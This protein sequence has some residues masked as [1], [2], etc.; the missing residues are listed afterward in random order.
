[1][2][3]WLRRL[4]PSAGDKQ[5]ESSATVSDESVAIAEEHLEGETPVSFGISWMQRED[6]NANFTNWLFGNDDYPD[7]FANQIEIDTLE[8]L[9]KIVKSKQSGAKLVRRIPGVVPQLLQNLRT[10]NYSVTEL[11]RKISHD[12]VLV[13]AV[14]RIAN[15][16]LYGPDQSVKNIEHA[17]M[18]LGQEGLR[19]LII[20][21]AFKPIIGLNSGRFTKL[22]AP[23]IWDQ[24]EKCAIAN[25]LL[26]VGE[27]ID[28]F[29]AFLAGLIQNVGLIV[30]LHVIDQ[31]SDDAKD[32]GSATFCNTLINYARI[33]SCSIGREWRF[34]EAITN[35]IEEQ[36]SVYNDANLSPIGKT[37]RSGDFL[38]KLLT[39]TA[40]NQLTEANAALVETLSEKEL[41]CFEELTAAL[42]KDSE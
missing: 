19:Q 20:N 40:H 15:S 5:F 31:M 7:L 27:R 21:V 26:A 38:S 14:I 39:L 35:A 8:A 25:R 12:V 37:L 33:L 9:D 41:A 2:Y 23:K 32:I 42:P 30:S 22:I 13:E 34:P 4:F 6:L 10:E 3:D 36:G 16:S 18:L 1:M 24:S 17:V 28:P 29:E 11:A